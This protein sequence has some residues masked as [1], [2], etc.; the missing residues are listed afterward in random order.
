MPRATS[1]GIE[2]E[3]QMFGDPSNPALLL[4]NG[5]G[6]QMIGW[7][8]EFCELLAGRGF[9]VIRFDNRDVGLS[10]WTDAPYTLEDMAAD[11]AGLLDALGIPAAHVVGVS[12]G[13]F[14]GQLVALN[15]PE[16]VRSLTSIM[17]GPN[18]DDQVPPTEEAGAAL[19]VPA[20]TREERIEVGLWA[21]QK[22]LGSA[23]PYDEGYER[24]RITAAVERA[25]NP[26]GFARQLRA[27]MAAPSRLSRLKSLRVPALVIHGKD[28]PLV[29]V[30]NGRRVA[31]AIPR[32]RLLEV[33][34]MGHDLP[35]R[36]WAQVAD[37][38]AELAAEKSAAS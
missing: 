24:A 10:T 7:D 22:L 30:D 4:V 20:K 18:G 6:G 3:Y 21:K 35:K 23:D 5:L 15:H 31:A 37:A 11:A 38:I 9:R 26:P 27:I 8:D 29:P 25:F 34:G 19:L 16:R 36:V 17:S 33:E 12:M 2:L 28:D 32:A 13:G 1:N 14:I